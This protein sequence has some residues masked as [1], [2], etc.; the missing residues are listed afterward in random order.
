[1]LMTGNGFDRDKGKW[2]ANIVGSGNQALSF[3]QLIGYARTT[4]KL[5]SGVIKLAASG[6]ISEGR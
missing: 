1:M 5:K 3:E 4:L 2:T 6:L